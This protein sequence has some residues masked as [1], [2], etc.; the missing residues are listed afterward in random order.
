M[1]TSVHSLFFAFHTSL[2]SQRQSV[3]RTLL[4]PRCPWST[5]PSG[6]CALV[7]IVAIMSSPFLLHLF[8]MTKRCLQVRGIYQYLPFS[9]VILCF[10]LHTHLNSTMPRFNPDGT[11]PLSKTGHMLRIGFQVPTVRATNSMWP[12]SADGFTG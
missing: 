5:L 7:F 10:L 2:P 12:C 9:T 4:F 3:G 6:R 8:A 11:F 1:P